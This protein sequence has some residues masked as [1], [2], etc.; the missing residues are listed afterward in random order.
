MTLL[1]GTA[2]AQTSEVALGIEAL[3]RRDV[4]GADVYFARA[5]AGA[6]VQ[7]RPSAL[8]WRADVA[9]R[10]RGDTAAAL[11]YLDRAVSLARFNSQVLLEYARL[12][13]ARH[14]YR[15]AARRASEAAISSA[16]PERRG[17][18]LR[19]L[20]QLSVDAAFAAAPGQ[21]ADSIDRVQLTAARDSLSARVHRFH[22]RTSDARALI[23]AGALLGDTA[24]V[25]DGLR[26]YFGL[27]GPDI[28]GQLDSIVGAPLEQALVS[29][30]LYESAALLLRTRPG[31]SPAH[32]LRD[33]PAYAEFL[34]AFRESIETTY[35][36]SIAGRARP[37]D[38]TRRLNTLGRQ[39][40][41]RL[42]WQGEP[43]AYYPAA[44]YRELGLRFGAVISREQS[45][46]VDEL[47]LSHRLAK[48]SVNAGTA[49]TVVVLDGTVT[50]GIDDW[51]LDGAGGR[52][53]WVLRDT[54]YQRRTA[55]TET[56]FRAFLALTD[57]QTIPAEVFR[58]T[59]DSLADLLRGRRDSIG[60]LPGVAARIFRDGARTILDSLER[61]PDMTDSDRAAAFTSSV[62]AA[63]TQAS[64]VR[65]ETRHV[66]D[67]R[68]GRADS[69]AEAEFRAKIDEVSLAPYPRLALTAILSPNVGDASAHGQANRRIMRGLVHW[70][71]A[72]GAEVAGYDPAAPA[73]LALPMLTDAQL[74]EAFRSMAVR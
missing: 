7:L 43:P 5:A 68:A 24:A 57:P 49:A 38:V 69:D 55:F 42:Q 28:A 11:R 32:A 27:G 8:Q 2:A 6:N 29:G 26:S 37:G 36:A 53:A 63:L 45:R 48:Y 71:R 41:A 61:V 47:H 22:G 46:G 23:D 51:I 21:A 73:L 3:A 1:A 64:I 19:A 65:H 74:R 40:W 14:R 34:R 50:A 52:A 56:P 12:E 58:I 20:V 35:R 4:R 62:Y 15:A 67:A 54:I 17:N 33:V 25:R 16:D 59:R 44:L 10:I 13:A 31:E 39:L 9:W 70:I 72:H 18:V 66:A 60:F 30:R